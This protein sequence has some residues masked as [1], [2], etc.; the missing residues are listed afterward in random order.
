MSTQDLSH[1]T[2]VPGGETAPAWRR[3]SAAGRQRHTVIPRLL[4]GLPLL[5]IGMVHIDDSSLR[6]DPLVEAAGFPLASLLSP[7]AVAIEVIAG[8]SL[9]LGFW[10]RLG[11]LLAVPVMLGA[12][13]A[14]L[15]IDVWPNGAA[16]EPPLAL[17]IVVALAAA[18][19][20]WRG[21]GRWSLDGR[22]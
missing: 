21:A 5:G 15:A 16:N 3:L 14:H 10:A 4:A 6:M 9:L 8:L 18:Y 20:A 22:G 13:Y 7:V 19:I 1:A 12:A 2:P 17:P 11:G